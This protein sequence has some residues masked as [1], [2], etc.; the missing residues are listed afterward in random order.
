[1]GAVDLQAKQ[2]GE[3]SLELKREVTLGVL[4]VV[5][6]S[7]SK[8]SKQPNKK[9]GKGRCYRRGHE[10]HYGYNFIGDELLLNFG[11]KLQR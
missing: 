5:Q 2:M 9:S 7:P 11:A 6:K 4:K 1:M 10:G 8:S 3:Q